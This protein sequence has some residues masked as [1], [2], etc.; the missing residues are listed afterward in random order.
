[1]ML[2]CAFCITNWV[3]KVHGKLF[4]SSDVT[5]NPV[6]ANKRANNSTIKIHGRNTTNNCAIGQKRHVVNGNC[7]SHVTL[8]IRTNHIFRPHE[9]YINDATPIAPINAIAQIPWMNDYQP[10]EPIEDEDDYDSDG[11]SDEDDR[12]IIRRPT[13]VGRKE[14]KGTEKVHSIDEVNRSIIQ[15]PKKI[16]LKDIDHAGSTRRLDEKMQQANRNMSSHKQIKDL[17]KAHRAWSTRLMKRKGFGNKFLKIASRVKQNLRQRRP[18]RNKKGTRKE[19]RR[20]TKLKTKRNLRMQTAVSRNTSNKRNNSDIRRA[21]KTS[22]PAKE[23][24]LR[25][26]ILQTLKEIN[27][28]SFLTNSNQLNKI[29]IF[30]F[31]LRDIFQRSLKSMIDKNLRPSRTMNS[32]RGQINMVPTIM[33]D[34]PSNVMPRNTLQF[35]L[36]LMKFDGS[37]LKNLLQSKLALLTLRGVK[38]GLILPKPKVEKITMEPLKDAKKLN[39]RPEVPKVDSKMQEPKKI[40]DI[41]NVKNKMN[42][43]KKVPEVPDMDSKMKEQKKIP[44]ISKVQEKMKDPGKIS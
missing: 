11:D 7:V 36:H 4:S 21:R 5:I 3:L 1:M 27:K 31:K 20:K 16:G 37:I 9:P 42:E 6:L 25:R 28:K 41:P 43:G 18:D 29:P 23:K 2:S 14:T 8:P 12:N 32:K 10:I 22:K 35:P 13:S 19:A 15:R 17:A 38:R 30:S 44:E 34:A 26:N 40:P 39:K 24:R 33:A